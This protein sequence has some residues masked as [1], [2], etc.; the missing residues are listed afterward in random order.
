E[1]VPVERP[2]RRGLDA[3]RAQPDEVD[4]ALAVRQSSEGRARGAVDPELEKAVVRAGAGRP[5][6]ADLD[7]VLAGADVEEASVGL[8]A[9][10]EA[11]PPLDRE[12]ID[13]ALEH[14]RR[15]PPRGR[16]LESNEDACPVRTA[17]LSGVEVV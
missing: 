7:H 16:L 9:A 11:G 8:G 13:L 12:L 6:P 2:T 3:Q 15:Q 4:G 10:V 17:R 14:H 5:P 1:L